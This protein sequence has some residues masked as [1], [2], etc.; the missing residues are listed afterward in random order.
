MRVGYL[1]GWIGELERVSEKSR[2]AQAAPD[3]PQNAAREWI[4]QRV[5]RNTGRHRADHQGALAET[6]SI[7]RVVECLRV[8][9]AIAA[10]QNRL[11]RQLVRQTQTRAEVTEVPIEDAAILPAGARV[12]QAAFQAQTGSLQR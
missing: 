2:Q 1:S 5:L 12:Q 8:D 11:R 10:A 7:A 4:G 3:R 6:W 9:Q